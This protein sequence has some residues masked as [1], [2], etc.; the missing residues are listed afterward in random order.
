MANCW[1]GRYNTDDEKR[2][3]WNNCYDFSLALNEQVKMVSTFEGLYA[4]DS[5][6]TKRAMRR[7]KSFDF[8]MRK[9][10]FAFVTHFTEW[11]NR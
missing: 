9:E 8:W 10:W 5:D 11:I 7:R 3:C 6:P 1:D 4:S 2:H